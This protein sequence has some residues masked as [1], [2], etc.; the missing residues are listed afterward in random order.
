MDDWATK[1]PNP[2]PLASAFL[3]G[4]GLLLILALAIAIGLSVPPALTCTAA[5]AQASPLAQ[6]VTLL[7]ADYFSGQPSQG[8][9]V[10]RV[11]GTLFTTT[12][13]SL[14]WNGAPFTWVDKEE[15]VVACAG[16]LVTSDICQALDAK[17]QAA[18]E[19]LAT[20]WEVPSFPAIVSLTALTDTCLALALIL[21]ALQLLAAAKGYH[22]AGIVKDSTITSIPLA[23][24]MFGFFVMLTSF[25]APPPSLAEVKSATL[26]P[27]LINLFVNKT[28]GLGGLWWGGAQTIFGVSAVLKPLVP[29]P[30]E[31]G[32]TACAFSA[33]AIQ[34]R[35]ASLA[36][37]VRPL[38]KCLP[39]DPFTFTLRA[40]L[41]PPPPIL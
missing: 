32:D 39:R 7:E 30:L 1:R 23:L 37:I 24:V 18:D 36:T 12:V 17:I 13:D 29:L 6:Q 26:N 8:Q 33:E 40:P 22:L 25:F 28:I 21:T 5:A 27:V 34:L 35:T 41:H 9:N 2:K 10:G 14:G 31:A 3:L 4:T 20:K 19:L 15:R 16:P 11:T 38:L